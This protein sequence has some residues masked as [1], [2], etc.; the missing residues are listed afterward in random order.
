MLVILMFSINVTF[1]TNFVFYIVIFEQLL[2][3]IYF[4]VVV[5]GM[6]GAL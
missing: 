2:F 6:D 3:P 5:V 4:F 1:F